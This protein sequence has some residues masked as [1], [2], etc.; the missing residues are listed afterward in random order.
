MI[1]F[2]SR[3][4]TKIQHSTLTII[5]MTAFAAF[6]I[7]MGG[8]FI[9]NISPLKIPD[10]GMHLYNII[11]ISSGNLVTVQ[12][13]KTQP[14]IMIPQKWTTVSQLPILGN[15]LVCNIVPSVIHNGGDNWMT[16]IIETGESQSMVPVEI[17]NQYIPIA[18]APQAV[19][20]SIANSMGFSMK[21]CYIFMR[22]ANLSFYVILLSICIAI[23]PRGK[24][25]ATILSLNPYSIFMASSI[26]SDTYTIALTSLF[27][28]LIFK[29]CLGSL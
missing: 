11:S 25:A 3:Y 7:F 23:I 15:D 8:Y 27:L 5:C 9:K 28:A 17:R 19:A 14:V 18:W 13:N 12:P 6:S 29:L 10:Y 20:L 21:N 2:F 26:S 16:Q 22:L 1:S 4:S 24:I